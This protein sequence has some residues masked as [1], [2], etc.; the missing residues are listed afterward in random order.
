[1][2]KTDARIHVDASVLVLAP[3]ILLVVDADGLNANND[4]CISRL[5]E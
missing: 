1:M 2:F 5:S 3:V 4:I